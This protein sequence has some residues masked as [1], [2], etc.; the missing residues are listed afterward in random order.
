MP[1]FCPGCRD[2]RNLFNDDVLQRNE[3]FA[4]RHRRSSEPVVQQA[5]WHHF[6]DC[7]HLFLISDLAESVLEF[8]FIRS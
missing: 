5:F 7:E 8:L 2:C 4:G 3:E 1:F 6:L